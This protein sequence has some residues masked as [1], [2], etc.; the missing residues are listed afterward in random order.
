M[1][2]DVK[3]KDGKDMHE[4]IVEKVWVEGGVLHIKKPLG[5]KCVPLANIK[6]YTYGG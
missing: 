4:V 1:W 3:L 6:E 5:T 2:V